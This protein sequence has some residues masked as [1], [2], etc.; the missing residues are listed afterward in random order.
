M[1]QCPPVSCKDTVP[2]PG[3]WPSDFYFQSKCLLIKTSLR[4]RILAWMDVLCTHAYAL[5]WT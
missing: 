3:P 5:T 1:S 2:I 4:T